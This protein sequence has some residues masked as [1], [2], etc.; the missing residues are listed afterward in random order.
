MNP[1]VLQAVECWQLQKSYESLMVVLSSKKDI[2]YAREPGLPK[3]S[4]D[5]FE[6]IPA[7][8]VINFMNNFLKGRLSVGV[9]ANTM[10]PAVFLDH[11]QILDMSIIFPQDAFMICLE[12]DIVQGSFGEE[13]SE[14]LRKN[15]QLQENFSEVCSR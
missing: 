15:L 6:E 8:A 11:R 3:D 10:Q 14:L 1:R 4:Q 2:F 7:V 5:C 13:Q 12:D 9:N